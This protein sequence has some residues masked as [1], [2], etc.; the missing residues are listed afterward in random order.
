MKTKTKID[1]REEQ[2][3]LS[4]AP[5]VPTWHSRFQNKVKLVVNAAARYLR[6]RTQH[7]LNI[8][9]KHVAA[10]FGAE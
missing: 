4:L 5:R 2:A 7:G 1:L 10:S 3:S 6:L 8:A 9:P